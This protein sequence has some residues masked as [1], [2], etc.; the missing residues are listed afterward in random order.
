VFA[1]LTC[2]PN[3]VVAPIH[4]KATPVLLAEEDEAKW[5]SRSFGEAV[6]LVGAASMSDDPGGLKSLAHSAIA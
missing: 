1:F 6:S 5:L 2:E 4:P 3:P